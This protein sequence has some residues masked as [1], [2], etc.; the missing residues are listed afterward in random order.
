M[1]GNTRPD[2]TQDQPRLKVILLFSSK[3]INIVDN[4]PDVEYISVFQN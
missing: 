1:D 4:G 3:S 2:P